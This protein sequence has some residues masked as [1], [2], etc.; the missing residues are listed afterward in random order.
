MN[1]WFPSG[2]LKKHPPFSSVW[3]RT[4]WVPAVSNADGADASVIL[5]PLQGIGLPTRTSQE[6]AEQPRVHTG[7]LLAYQS[8]ARTM[9][10]ILDKQIESHPT[11][12]VIATGESYSLRIW[13][14]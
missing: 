3:S 6:S 7:F 10:H 14:D 9:L 8:I 13:M 4:T 2:E 11:Y 5:T 12:S 1:L